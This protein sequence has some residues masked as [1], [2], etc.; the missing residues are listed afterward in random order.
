VSDPQHEWDHLAWLHVYGQYSWHSEATI[1][2]TKEGLVALRDALTEAIDYSGRGSASVMASD[3]EGYRVQV[4]R[5]NTHATLGSPEYLFELEYQMGKREAERMV[6]VRKFSP[7]QP[8]EE[9]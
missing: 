8:V 9:K 6:E 2:G 7:A 4:E 3:G 5:V 1:R